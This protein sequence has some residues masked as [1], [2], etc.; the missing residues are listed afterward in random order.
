MHFQIGPCGS[1]EI[2]EKRIYRCLG[3]WTDKESSTVYTFTKRAD[4]VVDTYECFVGLMA[5]SVK[6]IVIREAG[7]SCF[8]MLD[9]NNYGMEMNQTGKFMK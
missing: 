6:R 3:Q 2:Y 8:K 4:D 5:G 9:F 1:D 7:E